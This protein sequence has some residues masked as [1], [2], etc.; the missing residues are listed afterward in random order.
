MDGGGNG[1]GLVPPDV[2]LGGVLA[3]QLVL[4]APPMLRGASDGWSVASMPQAYIP[5]VQHDI[6]QMTIQICAHIIHD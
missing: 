2:G 4:V 1:P 3:Y 5:G 6:S